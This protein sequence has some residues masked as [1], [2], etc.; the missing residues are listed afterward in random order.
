[1]GSTG[2]CFRILLPRRAG[3][4]DDV[5]A[6]GGSRVVS[7]KSCIRSCWGL[8]ALEIPGV[9]EKIGDISTALFRKMRVVA[10]AS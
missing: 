9:Q 7:C 4:G 1:M 5:I 6:A 2:S 3:R 8:I 10:A